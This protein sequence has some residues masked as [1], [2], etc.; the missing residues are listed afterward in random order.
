M[1][2]WLKDTSSFDASF[3]AQIG[4]KRE[5]VL[6]V[7]TLFSIGVFLKE[8]LI[9]TVGEETDEVN[10]FLEFMTLFGLCEGTLVSK[11]SFFELKLAFEVQ[12]RLC[13][14]YVFAKDVDNA[15]EENDELKESEVLEAKAGCSNDTFITEVLC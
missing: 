13:I 15:E 6:I 11:I 1:F 4:L 3:S 12:I 2:G 10:E 7:V 5:L 14:T 9:E 8:V